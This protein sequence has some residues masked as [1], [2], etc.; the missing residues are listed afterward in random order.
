MGIC[1]DS[2]TQ[3]GVFVRIDASVSLA[4]SPVNARVPVSIS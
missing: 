2:A 1:P 4:S 3:S